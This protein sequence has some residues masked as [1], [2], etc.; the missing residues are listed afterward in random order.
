MNQYEWRETINKIGSSVQ[1]KRSYKAAARIF[2]VGFLAGFGL[3]VITRKKRNG[4]H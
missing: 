4:K 2:L 1:R 3:A